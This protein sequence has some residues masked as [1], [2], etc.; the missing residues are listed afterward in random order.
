MPIDYDS[1]LAVR[2]EDQAAE[3][4]ARDAILY[5]LSVGFGRDANDRKEFSYVVEQAAQKTVPTLPSTLVPEDFLDGHGLEQRS[6][7]HAHERLELY[8]P[9]PPAA[10]VLTSVGV[11]AA[12]PLAAARGSRLVFQSE[13]RMAHDEA[14]LFSL[15]RSYVSGDHRAAEAAPSEDHRLPGRDADLVCEVDTR[16]DQALLF[17]LTA[18]PGTQLLDPPP[19][20]QSNW[21]GTPLPPRCVFGI[22][23]RAILRTICDYD[24]TLV[25][26]MEAG[27]T[28]DVFP[29]ETLTIEMW[30]DRNIVS[31]RALVRNRSCVVLDNGKCTLAG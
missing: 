7:R 6:W 15:S 12:E 21:A 29:G 24:F 19:D 17:R 16:P 5:A 27:F 28:A 14:A 2:I 30:Q 8:R 23:C 31:F 10:R 11:V 22:A 26:G 4:F 18:R 20:R 3:Y 13:V 1:L 25:R 9:L